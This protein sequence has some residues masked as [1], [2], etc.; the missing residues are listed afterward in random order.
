MGLYAFCIAFS[1][2]K[3]LGQSDFFPIQTNSASLFRT[4]NEL[5]HELSKQGSFQ[6]PLL[7]NALKLGIS[8]EFIGGVLDLMNVSFV[9]KQEIF[10]IRT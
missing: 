7:L 2:F 1:V 4:E 8:G 10:N 3:Q 5:V 9:V 6:L